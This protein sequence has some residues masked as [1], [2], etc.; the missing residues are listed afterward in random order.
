MDDIKTK[1][2]INTEIEISKNDVLEAVAENIIYNN[3]SEEDFKNVRYSIRNEI[4]NRIEKI[5]TENKNEII[6]RIVNISVEKIEKKPKIKQILF[7]VIND[8][9]EINKE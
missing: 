6:D 4:R 5:F 7:D 9:I 1:L 2:Q 8:I 3:L